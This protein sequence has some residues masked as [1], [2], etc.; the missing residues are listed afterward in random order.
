MRLSPVAVSAAGTAVALGVAGWGVSGMSMAGPRAGTRMATLVPQLEVT[1]LFL[2]GLP[3]WSGAFA[4]ARSPALRQALWLAPRGR[5]LAVQ[6]AVQ[7][8]L[9]L[10][11]QI[12]AGS[13]LAWLLALPAAGGPSL[14][15][16]ARVRLL[17][18]AFAL[19]GIGLGAWASVL[20][21]SPVVPRAI[22]LGALVV[23]AA[24]PLAVAPL[25]SSF[26]ASS[27][28][29]LMTVLVDPW[30]VTAGVSGLDLLRM[31]WLYA[32]SPLGSLE[33]VYPGALTGIV[34][35]AGAGAALLAWAVR[36]LRPPCHEA[37]Q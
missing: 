18:M 36:G 16:L 28:L 26:G 3:R 23:M 22:T 35:Y 11:L 37:W 7:R 4:A 20:W 34:C 9:G 8:E 31:G 32:L 19:F 6:H 1:A 27:G 15:G 33:V 30:I 10:L 29:L 2:L 13:T 14:L 5:F 24:A 25:T 21:R 12:A 17:L